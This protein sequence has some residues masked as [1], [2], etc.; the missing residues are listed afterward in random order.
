MSSILAR[1]RHDSRRGILRAVWFAMLWWV[2]TIGEPTSWMV[3]VPAVIAATLMSL[4]FLPEHP[5]RW[6][7]Q[8]AA[9]FLG[10][11]LW[12]SV[13]GGID[14]AWRAFHPR[15]PLAPGLYRYKLRLPIGTAQT[16]C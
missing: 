10:Y 16:V 14:V 12:Q 7:V 8:G 11:F 15:L 6:R 2:V 9:R 1:V 3:G 13:M 4:M 5:W